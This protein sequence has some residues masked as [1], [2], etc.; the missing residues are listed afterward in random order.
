MMQTDVLKIKVQTNRIQ[1]HIRRT[2]T[3]TTAEEQ[4]I[5]TKTKALGLAL[6]SLLK[7]QA[8]MN[9]WYDYLKNKGWSSGN[10]NE[11]T[12]NNTTDEVH[13][14]CNRYNSTSNLKQYP[15]SSEQIVE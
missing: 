1:I 9:E 12:T 5:N 13:A 11:N 3:A 2:F 15:C 7:N 4:V 6:T 10:A 14:L 8:V